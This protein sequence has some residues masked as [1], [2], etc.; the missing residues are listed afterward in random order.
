MF[1]LGNSKYFKI[2]EGVSR[3]SKDLPV[4]HTVETAL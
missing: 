1:I 3:D 4:G 2:T